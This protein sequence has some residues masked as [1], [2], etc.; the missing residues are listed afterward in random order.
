MT[1]YDSNFG[2]YVRDVSTGSTLE[3]S[4]EGFSIKSR[5]DLSNFA[6]QLQLYIGLVL[7]GCENNLLCYF[8]DKLWY[9]HKRRGNILMGWEMDYNEVTSESGKLQH[10]Q[11]VQRNILKSRPISTSKTRKAM[12]R[13]TKN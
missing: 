1:S 2:A 11:H 13:G 8:S 10:T 5:V 3:F 9:L 6:S 7:R 4:V 12:V